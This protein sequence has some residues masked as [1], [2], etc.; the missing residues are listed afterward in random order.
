MIL[1]GL[2][3]ALLV[4]AGVGSVISDTD[5]QTVSAGAAASD[6]TTTLPSDTTST[7]AEPTTTEPTETTTTVA[8]TTSQPTTTTTIPPTTTTTLAPD[9]AIAAFVGEFA[10][11]IAAEDTD[12]LLDHLHS[13]MILGYGEDVCRNFI[14][15][16]ILELT[17]Y[18]LTGSVVGPVSKTLTTGI[19]DVTVSGI[20]S[21]E[22]SFV[23]Q[24][25]QFDA[26]ADFVLGDPITWLAICR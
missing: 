26:K 22:T 1:V 18:T 11:A 5:E 14:N 24:G 7:Q 23:F 19:G 9:A 17:Q 12:W 16:E 21:A 25:S 10:A 4:S 6:V 13:A 8:T 2:G 20:Y 3:T 15:V